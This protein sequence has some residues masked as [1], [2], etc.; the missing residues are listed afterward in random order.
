MTKVYDYLIRVL[1]MGVARRGDDDRRRPARAVPFSARP[2]PEPLDTF[3][4]M[5]IRLDQK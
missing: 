2:T 3:P 1:K 4:E 5:R